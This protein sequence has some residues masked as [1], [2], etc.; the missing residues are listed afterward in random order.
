MLV[1]IVY[2][3]LPETQPTSGRK[4]VLHSEGKGKASYF[5]GFICAERALQSV[6]AVV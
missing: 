3:K 6:L 1:D 5:F 4:T 2:K